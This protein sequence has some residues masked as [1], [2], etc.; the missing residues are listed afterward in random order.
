MWP[1]RFTVRSVTQTLANHREVRPVTPQERGLRRLARTLLRHRKAVGLFWLAVA[2]VGLAL[3]GSIT[4]GFTS[5]ETLPGLP[6]YD[7]G[8]AIEH[9]YGNGGNNSPTVA[10]VTLPPGQS[11]LSVA[12]EH[13]VAEVFGPLSRDRALRVAYYPVVK[14]KRLVSGNGR[15]ALGLVFGGNDV[16]TSPAIAALM[17]AAAPPGVAVKATNLNDLYDAPG[18][19]GLGIL[20][21]LVVGAVGAL[22]VLVLVFGS[23]LALVPLVIA[24][25][26][27]LGTFL[28][29][30]AISSVAPVSQ[31]VEYVVALI[32]LGIAI[33]YSLLVVSRWREE[34][35]RGLA[36]DEAVVVA[37]AT[38]GRAAAFSGATVAVGLFAL[39]ALPFAFLRSLGYG[40]LLV[41]VMTVAA[42]VT[43]LPV[44]LSAWG[45]RL[46]RRNRR[47]PLK[48]S[49]GGSRASGTWAAWSRAVVRHR[50]LAICAGLLILG[51]LLGAAT[52]MRVGEA[53]STA[54]ARTGPAEA[55][56]KA[57]E[58]AGFPL[59]A[60]QPI[61]VL[62][63]HATSATALAARLG[64]LPGA[65]TAIAP[66]GASWRRDGTALV[67]VIPDAPTSTKSA[68]ALVTAVRADAPRLAPGAR[69]AGDGAVETDVV[70]AFYARFPLIVSIVVLVSLLALA[71]AFRSWVLPVKAVVLNALSVGAAYGAL[72]LVWQHGYGSRAI[73]GIPA[74]GVV[75]DYVP[76][77]LFA[78]LFG[79]SMD[80]EV[81]II[82][83]IKEA[84]DAGMTTDDAVVE[85]LGRTG[86]LVTSAAVILFFAFAALAS[87]PDLPLKVFATGMAGGI[88]LDATV[89]RALLVPALV[90]FLG[91][92]A[93]WRPTK[94]PSRRD[95]RP[96][97][98]E[99]RRILSSDG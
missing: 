36:N 18:S 71:R 76:L 37:M 22:A 39:V 43:L 83:R 98:V 74:T 7:A 1:R 32:G 33:D 13:E 3:V 63:P 29:L 50:L 5:S 19:G 52:Q 35:R 99:E 55:G 46:D 34:R 51:I 60:L 95:R 23:L 96:T 91:D 75:V 30:G 78:F 59:G 82:S 58:S 92:R 47:R 89:V 48:A 49:A 41:P 67:D 44:L 15:S 66:P 20:G 87:G 26:S 62:T 85:G 24:G 73:W 77:V 10:V 16:P 40:G 88:L 12:G 6:S 42:S 28:A 93:W 25:V 65:R 9:L 86:R 57:V 81:F 2:I 17:R 45:P 90:S 72:V 11:V 64:A 70:H 61:E 68:E 31:L 97:L 79:L 14:D 54:L 4:S 69:V 8:L 80:Y 94:L 27:I 56:L 84:H 38:A 53:R 21:E